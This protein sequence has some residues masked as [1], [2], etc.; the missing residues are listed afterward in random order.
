MAVLRA[1]ARSYG[2]VTQAGGAGL[3]RVAGGGWE[4][5]W[6]DQAATVVMMSDPMIEKLVRLS[7]EYRVTFFTRD[8]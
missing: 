1:G 4:S 3:G 6:E 2:G 8:R 7:P 5:G